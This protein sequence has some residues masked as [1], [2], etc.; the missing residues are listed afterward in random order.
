MLNYF[1]NK[2]IIFLSKNFI[3]FTSKIVFE[4]LRILDYL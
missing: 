1:D 2:Y 3:I 4:L